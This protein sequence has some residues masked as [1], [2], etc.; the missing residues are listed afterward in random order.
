[1]AD[2]EGK[3]TLDILA[4]EERKHREFL[5]RYKKGELPIGT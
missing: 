3:D 1:V 4:G 2:R 5:V